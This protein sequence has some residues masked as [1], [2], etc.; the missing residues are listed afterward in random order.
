MR[1]TDLVSLIIDNLKRRKGRVVLTA[2][3]VIIGTA[4]VVTLVSLGD[5]L[6]KNATSQLWGINDLSSVQVYP[7]YP[8]TSGPIDEKDIKK[9]T[10]DTIKQFEGMPGVTKV[11]I[12]QMVNAGISIKLDQLETWASLTG[13]NLSDL[14]EMGVKAR[15]GITDLSGKNTVVVGS[16]IKKNFYDPNQRPGDEPPE[17]PDLMGKILKVEVFKWTP[18]GQETRKTYR[19]EV[20]GVLE[21]TRGEADYNMYMNFDEVNKI[22]DWVA[23]KRSTIPSRATTPSPSRRPART[24]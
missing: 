7:G 3:G 13:V 10:P 23:G 20:V 6:K 19:L 2:I 14:S 11:I 17:E 18:D 1:L 21:E 22:N 4:A 24:W 15:L 9:I 5:G 12:K 8:E 16:A